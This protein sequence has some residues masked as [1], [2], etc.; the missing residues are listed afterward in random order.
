MTDILKVD[1]EYPELEAIFKARDLLRDGEIIAFPTETVYGLGA[2]PSRPDSIARLRELKGRPDDKP[3]AILLPDPALVT[4][5]VS[6]IP[7][8]AQALMNRYWPGPLTLVLPAR[9]GGA[10][11]GVR[12]PAHPVAR[13]LLIAVGEPISAPSA[14][15]AGK[16]PATSAGEVE[17]YFHGRIPLIL[18]SGPAALKESSTVVAIEGETCRVLREGIITSAM[19]HQLVSGKT[20]L[21]VCS[22]NTCRSPMA[23]ALFRKHLARKLGKEIDELEEVGYRI[24]SA[25]LMA[26]WGSR[27]TP[28]SERAMRARGCD[29]RSHVSRPLTPELLREADRIFTITSSQLDALK[30]F[31]PSVAS[32]AALLADG[33]I[34]DPFGGDSATYDACAIEIEAAVARLVESF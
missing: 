8:R 28:D 32:R 21:F 14:N 11:V 27:A 23:E 34:T 24:T 17:A 9:D 15:P 33:D 5:F 7:P 4:D 16:P 10:T 26:H 25:G 22:G 3:F 2:L 20:I 13:S 6:S 1:A 30:R 31:E 19:V 29:L 12:V 18:D